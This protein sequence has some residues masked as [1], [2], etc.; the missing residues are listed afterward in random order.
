MK[1]D[2]DSIINRRGTNSIKY[3]FAAER[4]KPE[5]LLPMWVADMDFAAPPEVLEDLQKAVSHGIF[6]Y[7]D[8]A[9]NYYNAVSAW[10]ASRYDL[11]FNKEDII[12]APGIVY[13]LAQII[14]AFTKEGEAVLIQ[15]P[16]YYPFFS[17]IRENGRRI[18]TNPLIYSDS[19][20]EGKYN[21]NF[22]DFE[23]KIK[24]NNVKMFILCSH[25]NP[26]SRVWTAEELEE[27]NAICI[28]HNVIII[29]DEIHCDF[30]WSGF[31]HVSFGSINEDAVITLSPSKTFNLAG[32][33]VSN[34]IVKN[35]E[36]REKLITEFNRSGYSQLN[37][38]GIIACQSAYTKGSPWLD[39][40]KIYIENNIKLCRGFLEQHLPKIKLS[41]PEATYLLWLDFSAYNLE[42]EELDRRITEGAKLWL[43]SGTT[44]GK[45]GKSFQRMNI[46][47]PKT[48]LTEALERLRKEFK[49]EH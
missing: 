22:E 37:T 29:S 9:E 48:V 39:A 17:L 42:Q 8:A 15:T 12:K 38:L 5:G 21:I 6:G 24:D 44:F 40:L 28:K 27:L 20:K 7:S 1:Y 33:Q 49:K 19:N 18:I 16:V 36:F 25:H 46:A 3:D 23:K 30:V 26:I 31:K 2:F 13:A 34:I 41:E 11:N 35:A 47:C 10:F 45:D 4:G 32:L 14:R 43:N